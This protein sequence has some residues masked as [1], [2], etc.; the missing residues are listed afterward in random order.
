[1]K[2]AIKTDIYTCKYLTPPQFDDVILFSDGTALTGLIFENSPDH[3]KFSAAEPK[4]LPVFDKANAGLTSIFRAK[5]R[6][7]IFP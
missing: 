3:K 4:D 2:N 5:I 6:P 7:S 1:M